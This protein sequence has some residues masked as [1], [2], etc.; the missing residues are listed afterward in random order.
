MDSLDLRTRPPR[1]CYDELDGLMFMPRTID[2]LRAQLPGGHSGEY[3]INGPIKGMSAYLLERLDISEADLLET[4]RAAKSEDE[5]AVWLRAHTDR[6]EYPR[7]NQTI[8]HIKPK[9]AED[10]AYFRALYA[11]TLAEHPELEFIVD[12]IDTDDRRMFA[13]VS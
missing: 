8:R 10:E 9:H 13:G 6:A 11:R 2:K 1:S 12:I 3:F 5:I 4:I 7:I